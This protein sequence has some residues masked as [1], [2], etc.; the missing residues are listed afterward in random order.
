M[1][2]KRSRLSFWLFVEPELIADRIGKDG[3]CPHVRPDVRARRDD[4]AARLLDPFQRF[5]DAVDHDVGSSA[6]LGRP[7][8][9]L[10][11]RPAHTS[12]VIEGQVAVS[13]F[14]DLPSEDLGVEARGVLGTV[15]RD[16]EI[17][18]LAVGHPGFLP[19]S[20]GLAESLTLALHAL[21]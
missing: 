3:K 7:V 8:L 6:L 17:T 11:P 5:G 13:A 12:R 19:R 14:P 4:F 15:R 2:S 18:D 10:D 20:I 9:F 21:P 16:F 1:K